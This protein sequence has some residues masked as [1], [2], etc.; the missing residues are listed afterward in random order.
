M[1]LKNLFLCTLIEKMSLLCKNKNIKGESI[2]EIFNCL[3]SPL[4]K[5]F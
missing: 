4:R 1:S 2:C 3:R 5:K